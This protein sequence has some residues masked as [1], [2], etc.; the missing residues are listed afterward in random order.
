[1]F[2]FRYHLVSLAAVFLALAVGIL[3]GA[4][5]SGKLGDAEDALTKNRIDS[6]NDQLAQERVRTAAAERSSEATREVLEDAYPALMDGRL[7]GRGFAVLF[8]GPVDG[9]VRS[10]VER[11]LSD[12]GAGTP[13]RLLALATPIDAEALEGSLNDDEELAEFAGNEGDFGA[14]GEALGRELVEGED[15]PLWSALSGQLVEERTGSTSAEVEGVVIARSWMPSADSGQSPDDPEVQSTETLFEGLLT[16][17]IGA[18]VPVIG[19]ETSDAEQSVIDEYAQAGA[20]SVDDVD[21]DVGRLALALL[22]AGGTPGH[23]GVKESAADGAVPPIEPVVTT[24][25]G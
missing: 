20:S 22:L 9:D 11:T 1:M 15:T 18:D 16:G 17:V 4:A 24:T 23:Y 19:V 25:S 10:A 13:V 5:I 12:A 8:L 2:T 6:L 14:L 3:L 21:T 7:E